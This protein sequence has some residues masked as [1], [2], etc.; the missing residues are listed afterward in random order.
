MLP[1]RLDVFPL[2]LSAYLIVL[3]QLSHPLSDYRNVV[4]LICSRHVSAQINT[5]H[6]EEVECTT[7]TSV[8]SR[9]CVHVIVVVVVKGD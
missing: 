9:N 7:L 3:T 1:V 5:L 8:S 4:P 6:S 2:F